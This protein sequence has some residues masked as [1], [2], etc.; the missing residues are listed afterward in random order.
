MASKKVPAPAAGKRGPS[1]NAVPSRAKRAAASATKNSA[2][3]SANVP[4]PL[5]AVGMVARVPVAL[6]GGYRVYGTPVQPTRR[7]A[8]QIAA[9]VAKVR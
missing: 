9:A 1:A 2:V 3:G 7:S 6:V 5:G 4:A 8:Q